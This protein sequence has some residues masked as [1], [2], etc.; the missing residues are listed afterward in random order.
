MTMKTDSLI[1]QEQ[2]YILQTYGRP[3]LVLERGNGVY[4]FDLD[5]NRY[6]DFVSGLAVNALGYGD[7]DVL[8][9]IEQQS[10]QLMHVSN[11][12]HTVPSTRLAKSLVESSF[13]DRVFF[14]NSG[15]ESWEAALKFCRKWGHA[16]GGRYKFV[17][18]HNSFHG[19]TLGSLSTTGQPRYQEGFGPLLPG[20]GFADFNDLASVEA[21]VDDE[22]CAVL[23][24]PIQAEGGVHV[25]TDAFLQ[26]L[27]KLCDDRGLLLVFD[28]IQVG[29]GRTGSLWAYQ[30]YGVEPDVM[31]LAKALGGGLPIGATLMTQRVADA[32]Q[33]GD[34]AATFGANPVVANVALAVLDKITADG[35]LEGV[36]RNGQRLRTG[37]EK[38]QQR[39]PERISEL[40]GR[41]LLQGAVVTDRPGADYLADFRAREILVAPCGADMVRFL[42]PLIVDEDR[43]DQVIDVFDEILR[44][45]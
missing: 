5:G 11:L 41:G 26:G 28:E 38:L 30:Q 29:M 6:L 15:T 8:K 21:L 45:S 23:V 43:V 17:A 34:H 36:A 22:T 20:V 18:F 25:A 24:E 2:K 27:R 4:L 19:R 13:A 1:E 12:Y 7:Y 35:F 10:A 39:W 42:P 37:L 32:L 14:C 16:A 33:A 9:A 44:Q 40:R 31:T 3:D